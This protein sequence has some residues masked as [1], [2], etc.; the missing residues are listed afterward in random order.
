MSNQE[1]SKEKFNH[2][3][4]ISKNYEQINKKMIEEISMSS[5]HPGL[6]GCFR[7]ETWIEFF[8][9]IIPKKYTISQGVMIIDSH[10]EISNEV[11][12]AVY[13]EQYTP[14]VMHYGS[15]KYIPIEAVALVIECKS[16]NP[17]KD[18][19]VNWVNSIEKL[20]SVSSGIARM[21]TGYMISEG[22]KSQKKT[23]PIKI[24]ACM[25]VID[26]KQEETEV[27]SEIKDKFDIILSLDKK[28][29]KFNVSIAKEEYSLGWWA[30]YL[31]NSKNEEK[32]TELKLEHISN[33]SLERFPYLE[34]NSYKNNGLKLTLKDLKIEGNDFL[35]L[36]F[37]LNQLL[38]LINNP[39]LF[40]HFAYADAFKKALK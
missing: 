29:E 31:N 36:N 4:S 27:F 19:L 15:L 16:K 5:K 35:S 24:L 10:G 26:K 33:K 20:E 38:M 37:Q 9:N 39:M 7:E 21:A 34:V 2:F 18:S 11:D 3:K 13:D 40:P 6:T 23:K 32:E 1:N 12:I 14:Y 17:N 30:E 25:K 8:R 28:G 22:A